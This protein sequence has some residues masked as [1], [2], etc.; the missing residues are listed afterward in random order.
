MERCSMQAMSGMVEMLLNAGAEVDALTNDHWT[1]LHEAALN[2]H[3]EA[4]ERL[5]RAGAQVQTCLCPLTPL[6]LTPLPTTCRLCLS[7]PAGLLK[8]IL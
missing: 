5:L 3:V 1:P 8:S 6:P 4:V 2:G 7:M